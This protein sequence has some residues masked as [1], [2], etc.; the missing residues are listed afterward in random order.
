MKTVNTAPD[1]VTATAA[2]RDMQPTRTSRIKSYVLRQGRLTPGQKEAL[3]TQWPLYGLDYEPQTLDLSQ[4]FGRSAP[5]TLEIGFGNGESLLTL[6][7]QHPEENFIGIEV[8]RP[9]VGRLLRRMQDTHTS[10][11]RVSQ[12]DAV[13]VL[14]EQIPDASLARLLLFFP[15]PW[16][17]K[18]H[19]KRRI[20]RPEFAELV[21]Q[22]LQPGGIWHMATDWEDYAM[23]MLDV[24]QAQPQFKNVA[25]GTASAPFVER[26]NTRPLTHFEQRGTKL[27]HGIWDLQFQNA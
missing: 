22:K 19:N 27:G 18:R 5:V 2:G 13:E 1:N 15:D 17:K 9:G 26:P 20:V 6:A 11:I 4:V 25:E 21:A 16:H 7:Q 3:E 23:H 8:H 14:M 24:M 12:H 10:N